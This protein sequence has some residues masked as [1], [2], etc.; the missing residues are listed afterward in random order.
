MS[1]NDTAGW[2]LEQRARLCALET[3]VQ[4]MIALNRHRLGLG[5]GIAYDNVRLF[6]EVGEM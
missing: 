4:G 6:E 3:E 5:R 2:L 1:N